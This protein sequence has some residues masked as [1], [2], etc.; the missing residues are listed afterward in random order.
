M[1]QQQVAENHKTIQKK[2][3][4]GKN[5]N[6]SMNGDDNKM[7]SLLEQIRQLKE[8]NTRLKSENEELRIAANCLTDIFTPEEIIRIKTAT[9]ATTPKRINL[10][11]KD[12]TDDE[13]AS[14]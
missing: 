12:V 8:E 2:R 10:E 9:S 5:Y 14:S 11:I 1:V 13:E 3:V 4:E 6:E 7:N